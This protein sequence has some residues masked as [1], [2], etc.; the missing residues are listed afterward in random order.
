MLP[1]PRDLA[2]A[3]PDARSAS[4]HDSEMAATDDEDEFAPTEEELRAQEMAQAQQRRAE[5]R[6]ANFRHGYHF[7]V[8]PFR[9]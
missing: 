5:R 4:P 7:W 8:G 2:S 3:V 1:S 6:R 9:F